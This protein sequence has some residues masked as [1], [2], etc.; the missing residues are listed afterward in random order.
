MQVKWVK[1]LGSNFNNIYQIQKKNNKEK[2]YP[3]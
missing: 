2:Q 3:N 1:I